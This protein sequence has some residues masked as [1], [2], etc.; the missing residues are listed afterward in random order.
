[1]GSTST[2]WRN[3]PH[4]PETKQSR[5]LGDALSLERLWKLVRI[6]VKMEGVKYGAALKENLVQASKHLKAPE[7]K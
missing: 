5:L 3:T 1:M 7:G 6:Y 4:Y 2:I